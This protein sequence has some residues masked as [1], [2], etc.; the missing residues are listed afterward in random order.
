MPE[1]YTGAEGTVAANAG[2]DI[3]DGTEDRRN[4]WLAIN[5]TR[6]YIVSHLA[7]L[8]GRI[9]PGMVGEVGAPNAG[10]VRTALGL[11]TTTTSAN[12]GGK[13]PVFSAAGQLP[14]G[15]PASSGHA[16][17]KGYVD[18]AISGIVIPSPSAQANGPTSTAYNRGATGSSWF[19]VY[20]NAQLQF[21]RNTSSI[22]YKENVRD[23]AGSILALRTVIFDRKATTD[24][25]GNLVEAPTD[26]VGFIAEEVLEELP[27]AV[28]YFDGQIDGINDRVLLT[29]AIATIQE[30]YRDMDLMAQRLAALEGS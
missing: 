23:W 16:A 6:D 20:M 14:T 18:A 10:Q 4:G 2:L 19:A 15:T 3:L 29:A 5:K 9:F 7:A 25:E 26:E 22:R 11:V 8:T 27:E 13:I 28:M 30:M 21:M 1:T 12:A 24:E 17:N